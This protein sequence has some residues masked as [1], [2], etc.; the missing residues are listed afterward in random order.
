MRRPFEDALGDLL[1]EYADEGAEALMS[2]LELQLMAL[3]EENP[4]ED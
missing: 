2:A 1:A 4:D 3:R